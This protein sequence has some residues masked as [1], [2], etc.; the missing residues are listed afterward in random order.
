VQAD[1]SDH[2]TEDLQAATVQAV[3]ER[4]HADGAEVSHVETT[5]TV[6]PDG[7]STSTTVE[8]SVKKP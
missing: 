4:H 1:R 2:S 8:D 7:T 5:T 6:N 3:H